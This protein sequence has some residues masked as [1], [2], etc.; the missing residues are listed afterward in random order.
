MATKGYCVRCKAN[1]EMEDEKQS[2][3][4]KG[5]PITKGKCP[6]CSTT[7]CRLGKKKKEGNQTSSPLP[8]ETPTTTQPEIKSKPK[9][10]WI[11]IE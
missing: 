1:I 2:L 7:V 9:R 5:V 6:K 4:K 11:P 3:T 10:I 8:I